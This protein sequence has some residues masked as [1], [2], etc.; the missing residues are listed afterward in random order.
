VK[1]ALMQQKL[2][3]LIRQQGESFVIPQRRGLVA[4]PISHK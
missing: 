4:E 1:V 2:G 3:W